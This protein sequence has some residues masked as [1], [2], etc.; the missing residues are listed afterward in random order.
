MDDWGE[1]ARFDV[2]VWT[3]RS[4]GDT[5]VMLAQPDKQNG[6]E[7]YSVETGR[8]Y[9]V[10]I[11]NPEETT[12]VAGFSI[13][14]QCGDHEE[15]CRS[16]LKWQHT[17]GGE[18]DDVPLDSAVQFEDCVVIHFSLKFFRSSCTARKKLIMNTSHN[19]KCL[20]FKIR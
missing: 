5:V 12:V 20:Y 1:V 7:S 10:S 4:E 8:V 9:E 17:H 3:P 6:V 14:E 15:Q 11:Y 16:D 19:Q 13:D 2:E 18:W